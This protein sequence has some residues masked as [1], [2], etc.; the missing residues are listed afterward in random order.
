MRPSPMISAGVRGETSLDRL[1]LLLVDSPPA[2]ALQY[3]DVRAA[4]RVLVLGFHK[5]E[6]EAPPGFEPGIEV[7]QTLSGPQAASHISNLPMFWHIEVLPS[8]TECTQYHSV[9]PR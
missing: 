5:G 8:I 3:P 9:S 6:L 1:G 4:A 7:L 2:A